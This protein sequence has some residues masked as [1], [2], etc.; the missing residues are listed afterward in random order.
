M[1]SRL[2]SPPNPIVH[3]S[4][5]CIENQSREL[6]KKGKWSRFL[7]KTQDAQAVVTLVRDIG[8]AL[9]IYKVGTEHCRGRSQLTRLG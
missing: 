1:I 4:L 3:R 5:V 2:S 6:L 8:R 7:D 9:L